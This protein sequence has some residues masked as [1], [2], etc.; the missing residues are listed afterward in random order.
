MKYVYLYDYRSLTKNEGY[1]YG[2]INNE[3]VLELIEVDQN[4]Y[5]G[6]YR[7]VPNAA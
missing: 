4:E 1:T 6:T 7:V 5:V 2:K 3:T